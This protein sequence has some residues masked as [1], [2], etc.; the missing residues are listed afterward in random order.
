MPILA[1]DGSVAGVPLRQ[2]D[3]ILLY[4]N[5]EALARG[6][7]Q[8]IDDCDRLNRLQNRAYDACRDNFNWSSRGQALLTAMAA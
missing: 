6:V 5:Y 7:L 2:D 8:V 1:L 4:Q 3:S